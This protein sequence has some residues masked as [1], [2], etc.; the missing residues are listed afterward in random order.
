MYFESDICF[1]SFSHKESSLVLQFRDTS[2]MIH[3]LGASLKEQHTAGL[4]I[5]HDIYHYLLF[6]PNF[7]T[8]KCLPK[9][10]P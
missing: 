5:F 6:K 8:H 10:L 1:L 9:S 7:K 4:L 2:G 3:H